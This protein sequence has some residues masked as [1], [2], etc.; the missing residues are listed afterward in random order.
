MVD[1]SKEKNKKQQKP[2]TAV[3]TKYSDNSLSFA[4]HISK[5]T[6]S[7]LTPTGLLSEWEKEFAIYCNVV[8]K[9]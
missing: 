7:P 9:H 4:E 2:Q 6:V 1:K 3:S 5:I 8:V